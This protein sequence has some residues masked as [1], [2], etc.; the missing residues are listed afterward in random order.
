[1]RSFQKLFSISVEQLNHCRYH[2]RVTKWG[3]HNT[4]PWKWMMILFLGQRQTT[5]VFIVH[6][7]LRFQIPRQSWAVFPKQESHQHHKHNPESTARLSTIWTT[8]SIQ[9]NNLPLKKKVTNKPR[10]KNQGNTMNLG[11]TTLNGFPFPGKFN[12]W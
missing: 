10:A 6:S 5:K 2:S 3:Y 12:I 7:R 11:P 4:S 8:G 9:F 1:M